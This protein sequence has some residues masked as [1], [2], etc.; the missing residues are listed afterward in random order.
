MSKQINL[1]YGA[2]RLGFSGSALPNAEDATDKTNLLIFELLRKNGVNHLDTGRLHGNAEERLGNL[3]AGTDYGFNIDTKW[4]GGFF[5]PTSITKERIFAD[6]KDSLS[7][8][9]VTKI[10]TFYLHSPFMDSE[11]EDTLIGIN[12]AYKMG[13]FKHFGLS[14]F[15]P[16][17]VQQVYDMCKSK[18]LVPP[19]VYQGLYNP[20]NRKTEEELLP[21]LRKLGIRFNAYSVL[22]GG[23]L[24]KSREHVTNHEGRFSKDQFRG[25][26]SKMYNNKPFLEAHEKWGNI[27]D[28]EGVTKL[29]L[30]Y[31]WMCYHS[32]LS[33]DLGDG[34]LLGGRL[35]QLE[36]T[37]HGIAH[38]PLPEKVVKKIQQ[39]W[40]R[41]QPHVNYIDNLGAMQ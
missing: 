5:D 30:A 7:K 26:Y 21:L 12:E 27:A 1:I 29:E 4:V 34:I 10:H 20:V 14:N 40:E 38:G 3:K 39:L 9:G 16:A 35:G 11:I 41:L 22:A 19:T 2:V 18:G 15:S 6:A 28:E 31:R 23:F 17:Q 36:E 25:L 8:L 32:S 13:I 37:F 33:A 24:M